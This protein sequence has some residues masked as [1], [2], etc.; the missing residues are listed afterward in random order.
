MF[1]GDQSTKFGGIFKFEGLTKEQFEDE[2]LSVLISDNLGASW[3]NLKLTRN[4]KGVI[5]KDDGTA[6]MAP[7]VLI[8]VEE[9][10]GGVY[11]H[12]AYPANTSSSYPLMFKLGMKP[13]APF[14]IKSISLLN[15]DKE[16]EW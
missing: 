4:M 2:R 11:V 16:E 12:W 15:T 14:C 7:G 1:E 8:K 3:M 9:Y 5:L 6:L 13:T 10:E